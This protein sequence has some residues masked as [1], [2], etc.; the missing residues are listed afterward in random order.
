MPIHLPVVGWPG[1]PQG[2]C[3][4]TSALAGGPGCKAQVGP[5]LR[6]GGFGEHLP[7]PPAGTAMLGRQGDGPN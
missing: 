3:E 2:K 6:R 4:L 7:T 1:I 5:D